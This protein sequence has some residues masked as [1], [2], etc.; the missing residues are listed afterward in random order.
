MIAMEE[1]YAEYYEE[2]PVNAEEEP[3]YEEETTCDDYEEV[4]FDEDG[5]QRTGSTG[6][7][8]KLHTAMAVAEKVHGIA[9]SYT[10]TKRAEAQMAVAQE[11]SKVQVAKTAAKFQT[12][13]SLI[14]RTFEE[15][16]C[17]LDD[18]R[19]VLNAAIQQGDRELI[20][21]AMRASADI[22]TKSPLADIAQASKTMQE[23]EAEAQNLLL[24]F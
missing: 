5:W 10:Q 7:Q 18:N 12:D 23:K 24:D 3:Y 19:T 22:V 21:A 1:N 16:K 4:D 2:L 8:G 20:L 14:N 9:E 13:Q 17:V 11:W 6:V 15:R